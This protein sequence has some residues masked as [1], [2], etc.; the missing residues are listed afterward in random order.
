MGVFI[1]GTTLTVYSDCYIKPLPY[2]TI[3]NFPEDRNQKIIFVSEDGE[4][5]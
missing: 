3:V 5:T 4:D 2:R 1:F